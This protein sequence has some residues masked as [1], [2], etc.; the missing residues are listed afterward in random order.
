MIPAA[1]LVAMVAGG[2]NG[3]PGWGRC[4]LDG[5]SARPTRSAVIVGTLVSGGARCTSWFVAGATPRL[6]P[7]L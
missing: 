4:G 2:A 6:S 1:Q 3:E 5:S 7:T